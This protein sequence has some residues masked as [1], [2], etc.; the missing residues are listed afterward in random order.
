MPP[1]S[2][3]PFYLYHKPPPHLLLSAFWTPH[4]HPFVDVIYGR[5]ISGGRHARCLVSG[6]SIRIAE[7]SLR[8]MECYFL[9]PVRFIDV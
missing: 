5:I 7:E 1:L 2:G 4:P 8:R 9:I 3:C 6:S